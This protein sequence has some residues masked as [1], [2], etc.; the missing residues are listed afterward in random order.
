MSRDV[1]F[2]EK[3]NDGNHESVSEEFHMPFLVEEGSDEL[4]DN[5]EQIQQQQ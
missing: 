2:H 5:N 3:I 4:D 1:V